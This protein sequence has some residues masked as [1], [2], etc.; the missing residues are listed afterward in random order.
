M[1]YDNSDGGR[2]G[3]EQA[4]SGVQLSEEAAQELEH[5]LSGKPDDLSARTQ[6]LGYYF[7]RQFQSDSDRH[8]YQNHVLWLIAHHPQLDVL[9]SPFAFLLRVL[10]GDVIEEAKRLW[11]QQVYAHPK[12]ARV[13]GSAAAFLLRNDR[14][15]GAIVQHLFETAQSVEPDEPE[16]SQKLGELYHSQI[17]ER[18][19]NERRDTARRSLAQYERAYGL[20]EAEDR[21]LLL[22]EAMSETALEAGALDK[23]RRYA[24]MQLEGAPLHQRGTPQAWNYGN[25]LHHGNLTLGRVALREGDIESAKTHLLEAGQTP[26]SPQLNSYGPDMRLARELLQKGERQSVIEFMRL[27]A[28]FW[29]SRFSRLKEWIALVEQDEI[30]DFRTDRDPALMEP[31]H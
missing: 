11:M 3:G 29:D 19:G 15:D 2:G 4:A 7:M 27:C 24:T 20:T 30:P 16:W 5:Q 17:G 14:Q 1:T 10:N 9:G 6:L 13:L 31:R 26:G 22:L 25:L 21:K 8:A 23:A 18:A 12:N 28:A